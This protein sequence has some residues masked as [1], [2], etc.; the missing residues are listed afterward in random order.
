MS[1]AILVLNAGSFSIKFA[2]YI[3]ATLPSVAPQLAR[4]KVIVAHL[5]KPSAGRRIVEPRIRILAKTLVRVLAMGYFR[6]GF[7]P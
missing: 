2:L 5:G 6:R 4:A 3:A 7:P 1:K